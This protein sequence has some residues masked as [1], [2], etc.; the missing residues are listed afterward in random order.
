MTKDELEV[1]KESPSTSVIEL[2][3]AAIFAKSIETGDYTRLSFLLDRAIGKVPVL[4]ETDDETAARDEIRSLSDQ[5]LIRL[6]S[7]KIPQLA[8]KTGE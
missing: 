8:G 4:Q 7:E 1:A 3:I 2:T 5:E 6:V